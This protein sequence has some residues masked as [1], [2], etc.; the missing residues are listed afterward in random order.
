M[1]FIC[2]DTLK[3]NWGHV[4]LE[5]S[6]HMCETN[7]QRS[8]VFLSRL[9]VGNMQYLYIDPMCFSRLHSLTTHVP[10]SEK[11]RKKKKTKLSQRLF[12]LTTTLKN[13]ISKTSSKGRSLKSPVYPLSLPRKQKL[14]CTLLIFLICFVCHEEIWI[15]EKTIR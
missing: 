4:T 1:E 14:R 6:I 11:R 7:F 2:C 3:S 5:L 13:R 12:P 9:R 8:V 15:I 10:L